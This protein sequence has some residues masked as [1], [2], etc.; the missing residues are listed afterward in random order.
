MKFSYCNL[1]RSY[2]MLSIYHLHPYDTKS[3][4]LVT[5]KGTRVVKQ[6]TQ[7]KIPQQSKAK[8]HNA[9]QPSEH[10]F[11]HILYH[12]HLSM[13]TK[14]ISKFR[15]QT[16]PLGHV[17]VAISSCLP[18]RYRGVDQHIRQRFLDLYRVCSYILFMKSDFFF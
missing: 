1:Q 5:W 17:N 12:S 6:Q 11:W 18:I 3:K 15:I 16:E 2:K 14:S 10:A 13:Y 9:A 4:L 8:P 7:G